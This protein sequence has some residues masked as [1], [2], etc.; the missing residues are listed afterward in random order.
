MLYCVG[1]EV[2]DGATEVDLKLMSKALPLVVKPEDF[3][4]GAKAMERALSGAHPDD[5]EENIDKVE[6]RLF[7]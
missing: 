2:S 6:I 7:K 3:I 4:L 1:I 5:S